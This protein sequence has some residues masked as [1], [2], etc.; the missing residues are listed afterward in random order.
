MAW[1]MA[2]LAISLGMFV[3][4]GFIREMQFA[5]GLAK[6]GLY[7]RLWGGILAALSIALIIKALRVKDR[8]E[9]SPVFT[10]AAVFTILALAIYVLA[11]GYAGF[12]ISTAC[13]LSAMIL[14]YYYKFV[15]KLR[16]RR[17]HHA[18]LVTRCVGLAVLMTLIIQQIF[19]RVLGVIL[20]INEI[21]GI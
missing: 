13:Y 17:P 9:L 5:Q 15:A 16:T 21:L 12:V 1:G 6:T 10:S 8:E 19:A 3:Y 11:L 20:P 2:F 18:V 14:F 4:S 7:I